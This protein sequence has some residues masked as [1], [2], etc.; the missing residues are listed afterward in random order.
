MVN[1]EEFLNF[2]TGSEISIADFLEFVSQEM[3]LEELSPDARRRIG[4]EISALQGNPTEAFF[5]FDGLCDLTHQYI[6]EGKANSLC[7]NLR[8]AKAADARGDAQAKA[9]FIRAYIDEVMEQ[10]HKTLT[11]RNGTTLAT[12]ARTL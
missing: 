11:R 8:A 7:A 3:K 10:V 1:L 2:D 9:R 5:S 12:L 6:D 4:V